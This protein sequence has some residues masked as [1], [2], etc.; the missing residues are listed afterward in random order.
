[1]EYR[2]E[3]YIAAC[4]FLKLIRSGY[5]TLQMANL[6]KVRE[7]FVYNMMHRQRE[8]ER[9]RIYQRDYQRRLRQDW[10]SNEPY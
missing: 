5:D 1:M 2:S 6:L 8:S 3:N 7:S 9:Q 10:N 4:D